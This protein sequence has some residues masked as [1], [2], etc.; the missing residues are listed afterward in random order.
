MYITAELKDYWLSCLKF[1]LKFLKILT[2]G[3]KICDPD[4]VLSQFIPLTVKQYLK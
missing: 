3:F 4:V 2:F 1:K